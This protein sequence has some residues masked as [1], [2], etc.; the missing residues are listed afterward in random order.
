MPREAVQEHSVGFRFAHERLSHLSAVKT[1]TE[2]VDKLTGN[3]ILLPV[4]VPS[5]FMSPIFIWVE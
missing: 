2:G 5:F 1:Q 3:P 4:R